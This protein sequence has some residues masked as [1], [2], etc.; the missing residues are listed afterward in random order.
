MAELAEMVK[1]RFHGSDCSDVETLW[2][3]PLGGDLYRLDNSPFYAYGVSWQDV[4]KAESDNDEMLEFVECVEKSG[5]R[6]VRVIFEHRSD[7]APAQWV[8]GKILELGCTF[9]GMQPRM[10]SV[11]IPPSV[12]LDEVTHLLSEMSGLQWEY[13]DPTYDERMGG[14]AI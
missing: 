6:T 5:N 2:A 12:D 3:V 4:V 10:V 1:I 11:N 7:E 13:A 8:L 14:D 9:E